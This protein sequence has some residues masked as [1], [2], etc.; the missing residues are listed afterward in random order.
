MLLCHLINLNVRHR[1]ESYRNVRPR[2]GDRGGKG[3]DSCISFVTLMI[4]N[5]LYPGLHFCVACKM[6]NFYHEFHIISYMNNDLL[7]D[8]LLII[9]CWPLSSFCTYNPIREFKEVINSLVTASIC[10]IANWFVLLWLISCTGT[11][12]GFAVLQLLS[13]TRATFVTSVWIL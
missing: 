9:L 13:S 4:Q 7:T 11:L 1:M 10:A 6:S 12:F 8:V 5:S 2:T 3:G